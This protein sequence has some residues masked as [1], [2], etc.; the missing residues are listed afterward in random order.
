MHAAFA[1][2]LTPA[3]RAA[4]GAS[5][6]TTV[7]AVPKISFQG[8]TNM[9]RAPPRGA[10]PYV[11]AIL[12]AAGESSY[13]RK[14]DNSTQPRSS[15]TVQMLYTPGMI[16]EL[17]T[18]IDSDGFT[19][20]SLRIVPP[21][22][23]H[24]TQLV[25]S[26]YES[27]TTIGIGQ[28]PPAAEFF[29]I[30]VKNSEHEYRRRT[31]MP[32][33]AIEDGATIDVSC[34]ARLDPNIKS[35]VFVRLVG[36]TVSLNITA[37]VSKWAVQTQCSAIVPYPLA[38]VYPEAA[39]PAGC[40]RQSEYMQLGA[41][42]R[43]MMLSSMR[44]AYQSI[45]GRGPHAVIAPRPL[46][47]LAPLSNL[48][49]G[50]P[51]DLED[52]ISG[53][54][55]GATLDPIERPFRSGV[56]VTPNKSYT[57]CTTRIGGISHAHAGTAYSLPP[58]TDDL[59]ELLAVEHET[60]VSEENRATLEADLEARLAVFG[61]DEDVVRASL[62]D[63]YAL[64]FEGFLEMVV[65]GDVATPDAPGSAQKVDMSQG[66]GGSGGAST[67]AS[68]APAV[69]LITRITADVEV[70]GLSVAGTP[71]VEHID[72]VLLTTLDTIT[73]AMAGPT[74]PRLARA[75]LMYA[76]PPY[77]V[78]SVPDDYENA[79][80]TNAENMVENHETGLITT[81]VT[82]FHNALVA[83]PMLR[84]MV[85][86]V[87]IHV[88]PAFI[89]MYFDIQTSVID[90]KTSYRARHPAYPSN[91]VVR[92]YHMRHSKTTLAWRL[93]DG[94]TADPLV[95]LLSEHTLD[96]DAFMNPAL[97][98]LYVLVTL[99]KA[100]TETLMSNI[101]AARA[102][103][104]DALTAAF[105][106]LAKEDR[107]ARHSR[108]ND[109]APK[110][111]PFLLYAVD[112]RAIAPG[113]APGETCTKTP[114]YTEYETPARRGKRA[115]AAVASAGDASPEKKKKREEDDVVV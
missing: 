113:V 28:E 99:P 37:K 94:D 108:R 8:N 75:L 51:V 65:R 42:P 49:L 41:V 5:F 54:T 15:A 34:F 72:A 53:S 25:F 9:A 38:G 14:F 60:E 73:V 114:F 78:A 36:F 50:M 10:V 68:F 76:T 55:S 92:K 57:R 27:K 31:I 96:L 40:V 64:K 20:A 70:G 47:V 93:A 84:A 62:Q 2:S 45:R 80:M 87:G 59:I 77:V 63:V 98:A 46:V 12:I 29:P 88:P 33:V 104:N 58:P 111:P 97:W 3:E 26:S 4:L 32:N 22:N 24:G 16:K 110:V 89:K 71:K 18:R 102:A 83:A 52:L 66:S 81:Q 82:Q 85:L 7:A 101:A 21:R 30:L 61:E 13:T 107:M 86:R 39:T 74:N 91:F 56:V 17:R 44:N 109:P 48:T 105:D 67:P 35:F 19:K 23:G 100:R 115:A 11:D 43:A 106:A 1:S 95:K 79:R 112:R 6:L 103:G 69:S 90:G